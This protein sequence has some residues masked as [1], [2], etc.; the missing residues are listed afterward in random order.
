MSAALTLRR[1]WSHLI[2]GGSKGVVMMAGCLGLAW[3]CSLPGVLHAWSLVSA[4]YCWGLP[5]LILHA[6][7]RQV[8]MVWRIVGECSAD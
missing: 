1:L 4:W 3:R 7:Q 5:P 2:V 8:V 6:L